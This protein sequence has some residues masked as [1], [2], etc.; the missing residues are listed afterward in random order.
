MATIAESF[1]SFVGVANDLT[2]S[3]ESSDRDYSCARVQMHDFRRPYQKLH[4]VSSNLLSIKS[5]EEA[6]DRKF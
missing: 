6:T 3:L 1:I 5:C 4:L 2:E